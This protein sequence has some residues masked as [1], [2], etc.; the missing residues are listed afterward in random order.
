MHERRIRSFDGTELSVQEAGEGPLVLLANGLGGTWRAWAP[1]LD[2]FATSH[3]VASWDYRGLYG[4]GPPASPD[5][6]RMEDH[7]HDL[8]V[9]LD[10]LGVSPA[11]V[12]GWSMGVQVAVQAALDLPQRVAALVLVSGA[13]GDPLAGVLHTPLARVVVPPLTHVVEQGAVPF[14]AALRALVATGRAP[15][16]LRALGVVAPGC[17]LQVFGAL[18]RDFAGLDWRVYMRTLRSLAAHDAWP[19]LPDLRLPVL[20]VGGTRDAFL[21]QRTIEATAAAIPGAELVLVPGATHYLPVEYPA[22]LDASI[23]RFLAGVTFDPGLTAEPRRPI[24]S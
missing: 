3:R 6:V 14:G 8:G 9:V 5:A 22:E 16:V 10:D 19:R 13:P 7:V 4:S 12:V 15:Q 11:V 20:V 23:R 2:R 18:A 24:G 21:P 1:F 17:D